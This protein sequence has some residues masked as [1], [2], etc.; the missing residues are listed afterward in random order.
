MYGNDVEMI[1]EMLQKLHMY[2]QLLKKIIPTAVIK[3]TQEVS[4][5]G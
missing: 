4:N 5:G 3:N 2:I 1:D